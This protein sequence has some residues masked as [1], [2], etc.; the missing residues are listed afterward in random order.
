MAPSG[1]AALA[2][3]SHAEAAQN[4]TVWVETI[5]AKRRSGRSPNTLHPSAHAPWAGLCS[6]LSRLRAL[7]A[8][9]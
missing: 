5:E 8:A 9:G 6:T 1:D 2:S 3:V 4:A 7:A